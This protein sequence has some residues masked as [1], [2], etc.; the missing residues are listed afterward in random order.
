MV[1]AR[2]STE[3]EL[4]VEMLGE[5]LSYLLLLLVVQDTCI[6]SIKILWL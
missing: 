4:T 6:N 3:N 5:G 2:D 1:E